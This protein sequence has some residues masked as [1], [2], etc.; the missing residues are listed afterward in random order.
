MKCAIL[1]VAALAALGAGCSSSH[2]GAQAL[3]VLVDVSGTYVDQ[4]P[5]VVDLLKKGILPQ[6]VPGDSLVVIRIDDRSYRKENVVASLTLDPRPSRAIA[7]K[8]EMA[9]ALDAFAAHG[10]FAKWTDIRGG[11]L[12]ASDYLRE[13][14]ASDKTIVVFSDMQE[15]LPKGTTRQLDA[16]ELAGIRVL[17]MNVKRLAADDRDPEAYR[18][19]LAGWD[20]LLTAAGASEWR[21]IEQP[22]TLL[23][24]LDRR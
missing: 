10:D 1:V 14:E 24:E 23:T 2:D 15:E 6:M 20:K 16:H 4:K 3:A 8:R 12:L 22:E 19:R 9:A 18:A 7:Q 11:I 21:S 13:A 17:A 5:Q